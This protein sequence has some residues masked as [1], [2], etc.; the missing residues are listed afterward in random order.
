MK[1]VGLYKHLPIEDPQSLVDLDIQQPTH[2]TGHD[3]LVAIKAISVNPLDTKVRRARFLNSKGLIPKPTVSSLARVC[4]FSH[5]NTVARAL[6]QE[7]LKQKQL[8]QQSQP[9]TFSTPFTSRMW[10]RPWFST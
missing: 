9:V 1:A 4:L 2:P 8:K 10:P 6:E 3:L 5:I 7:L